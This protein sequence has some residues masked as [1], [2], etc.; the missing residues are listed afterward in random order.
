MAKLKRAYLL[1]IGFALIFLIGFVVLLFSFEQP[2]IR[3]SL[4][5]VIAGYAFFLVVNTSMYRKINVDLPIDQSLRSA[6]THTYT[7]ISENIRFQEH[8]ALFIYPVAATAGFLMGL[9]SGG[10][11]DA[12]IQKRVILLI[13][14]GLIAILT[15]LS[16]Y[17]A[18]WMYKV[19]YGRCLKEIKQL[20]DELNNPA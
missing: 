15:P 7:F 13:L 19:S 12:L 5:L 1:S 2:L 8:V 10:D 17:L 20:I 18:R 16:F 6:L 9:A 3:G 4:I 14:L 11:V